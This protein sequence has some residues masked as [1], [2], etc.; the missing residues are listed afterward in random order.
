MQAFHADHFVLPCCP[1]AQLPD[2]K[3]RLLRDGRIRL[4]DPVMCEAPP[5]SD[6]ELALAHEPA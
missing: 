6:G 5:A 1:R 4:P 3:Y 2:G